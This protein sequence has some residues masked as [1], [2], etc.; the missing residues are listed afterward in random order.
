MSIDNSL[1]HSEIIDKARS[2]PH[3]PTNKRK[4]PVEAVAESNSEYYPQP[5]QPTS[6]LNVQSSTTNPVKGT[7]F[8]NLIQYD[9]YILDKCIV[10]T[11]PN[12]KYVCQ[13]AYERSNNSKWK[14]YFMAAK[15]LDV[16]LE[17]IIAVYVTN[18]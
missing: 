14:M 2:L 11:Y 4:A 17:V 13:V 7:Y 16:L 8:M 6:S 15:H 3:S 18:I 9:H 12:N 10:N 1:I 5:T